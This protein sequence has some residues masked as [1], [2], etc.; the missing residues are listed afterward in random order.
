MACT[1]EWKYGSTKLHAIPTPTSRIVPSIVWLQCVRAGVCEYV[2]VR[3]TPRSVFQLWGSF[4]VVYHDDKPL[5]VMHLF[6]FFQAYAYAV[7]AANR[8]SN[9]LKFPWILKSTNKST[10]QMRSRVIFTTAHLFSLILVAA[11]F[12]CKRCEGGKKNRKEK[13]KYLLPN[14]SKAK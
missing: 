13:K 5:P 9:V 14:S 7:R 6:L 10:R 8:T 12:E 1:S 3:P 2:F 4:H 11:L